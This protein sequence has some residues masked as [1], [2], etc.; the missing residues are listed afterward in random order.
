[1]NFSYRVEGIS[2]FERRFVE[3]RFPASAIP[4]GLSENRFGLPRV[5]EPQAPIRNALGVTAQNTTVEALGEHLDLDFSKRDGAAFA[6]IL[7]GDEALAS[8]HLAVVVG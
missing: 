2:E 4:L 8:F 3:F 5:R 1:M 7:K 6:V